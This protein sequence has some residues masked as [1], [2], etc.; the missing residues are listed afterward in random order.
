MKNRGFTLI[1]LMI[2]VA[3]LAIIVGI[4]VPAYNNQVQKSRRADGQSALLSAAQ[5]LERCF[6]TT[7]SYAGCAY[8]DTS[9]DGFYAISRLNEDSAATYTLQAAPQ[10]AQAADTECGTLTLDHLGRKGH[11]DGGT[12]CWGGS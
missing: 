7:N 3:I 12:R 10:G 11:A 4:A 9:Q 2:T 1:E 5:Q 6:T 8:T